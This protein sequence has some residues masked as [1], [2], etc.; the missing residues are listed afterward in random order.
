MLT[1]TIFELQLSGHFLVLIR[2]L[3]LQSLPLIHYAFWLAL[4]G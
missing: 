4:F 1:I 2:L 3:N